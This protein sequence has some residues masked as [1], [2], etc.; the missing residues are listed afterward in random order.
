MLKSYSN[1]SCNSLSKTVLRGTLEG[2]RCCGQQRKCWVGNIKEWTSPLPMPELPTRASCRKD[3]K[4][5]SADL[6][7]MSPRRP[8]HSR[9]CMQRTELQRSS[10]R[11]QHLFNLVAVLFFPQPLLLSHE[12]KKKKDFDF[13]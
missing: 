1:G 3:W 10:E 8:N 2:G 5:I 9:E 13:Q 6:T 4:T 7:L 12:S 11:V